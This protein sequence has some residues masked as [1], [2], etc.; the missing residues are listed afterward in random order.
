MGTEISAVGV[1]R[2]RGNVSH[3]L[4]LSCIRERQTDTKR[5]RDRDRQRQ[6]ETERD[7][8]AGGGWDVMLFVIPQ[9]PQRHTRHRK[10]EIKRKG[11]V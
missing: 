2:W 6:T 10:K 1:G 8:E 3:R 5:Q 7:R 4:E 11:S 9:A